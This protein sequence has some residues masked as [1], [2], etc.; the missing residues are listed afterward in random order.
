MFIVPAI[1]KVVKTLTISTTPQEILHVGGMVNSTQG[2]IFSVV[3]T[4]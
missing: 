3:S 2:N 4:L 1:K